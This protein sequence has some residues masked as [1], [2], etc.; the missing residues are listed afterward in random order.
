MSDEDIPIDDDSTKADSPDLSEDE[1]DQ[2]GNDG[3]EDKDGSS[4]DYLE[5]VSGD[6]DPK[7]KSKMVPQIEKPS[8]LPGRPGSGGYRL[9][10]V[11]Q[12][13]SWNDRL[14]NSVNVSC[15][16]DA[17]ADAYCCFLYRNMSRA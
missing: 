17:Q 5:S 16:V 4:S 8:G 9:P 14:F 15:S 1:D 12:Q 11:L 3:S 10:N 6:P 7:M 2:D 13:S